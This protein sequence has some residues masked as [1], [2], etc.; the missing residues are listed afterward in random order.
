MQIKLKVRDYGTETI[1]TIDIGD[2]VT[3]VKFEKDKDTFESV[4]IRTVEAIN[5]VMEN[6]Q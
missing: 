6:E 4:L 1:A 2:T 3:G 5:Q